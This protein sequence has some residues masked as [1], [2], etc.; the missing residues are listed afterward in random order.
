MTIR[1]RSI[2][3]SRRRFEWRGCFED[4]ADVLA[5]RVERT[6]MVEE[7]FICAAMAL[8]RVAEGQQVAVQLGDVVFGQ[9]DGIDV[10]EQQFHD[11]RVA[12][13]FLLVAGGKGFDI[14]IGEG[15]F[16]LGI[17][18]LAAFNAGRRAD[19]FEGRYT[20]QGREAFRRQGAQRP[21]GPLELVDLGDERED[22][23]GDLHGVGIQRHTQKRTHNYPID[24]PQIPR[25]TGRG[26]ESGGSRWR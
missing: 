16:D 5:V 4:H 1:S 26:L 17:A 9:V 21:P 14:E 13:D 6:D 11:L 19:A 22:F 7:R 15:A 18:K 10:R 24:G 25:W 8:I 2:F 20:A 3:F 23:R 12:C